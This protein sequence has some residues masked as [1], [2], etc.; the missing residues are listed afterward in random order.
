MATRRDGGLIAHFFARTTEAPGISG[1]RLHGTNLSDTGLAGVVDGEPIS[2]LS[3]LMLFFPLFSSILRCGL[4]WTTAPG[5][6]LPAHLLKRGEEPFLCLLFDL[7]RRIIGRLSS[8]APT[9]YGLPHHGQSRKVS[10]KSRLSLWDYWHVLLSRLGGE[11]EIGRHWHGQAVSFGA[12]LLP[13]WPG[14]LD[15]AGRARALVSLLAIPT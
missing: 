8:F 1:R 5:R 2:S 14:W 9:G 11:N 10:G 3:S 7:D 15:C 4:A 6:R 12:R 13:T